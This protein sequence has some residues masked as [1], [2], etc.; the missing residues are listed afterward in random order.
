MD[1]IVP[2]WIPVEGSFESGCEEWNG[3]NRKK[4]GERLH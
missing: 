3:A 2:D 1:D 4:R